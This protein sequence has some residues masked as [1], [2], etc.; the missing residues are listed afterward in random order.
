M[1][2]LLL[3]ELN[4]YFSS[5]IAY[6]VICVFLVANAVSLWLLPD[7]NLLDSGYADLRPFF[8]YAPYIFLFLIPA[9]TMRSLAEEKNLGTLESLITKPISETKIILAKYLAALILVL[10]AVLPTLIY[11]GSL[12]KLGDPVGNIDS[13][14]VMGSYIGLL[15]LASVYI[16]IGIFASSIT[17]SQIVALL[18]SVLICLV[19]TL[20]FQML[21]S[22]RTFRSLDLFLQEMGVLT[23]YVSMSRGVIDTRDVVYFLSANAVFLLG[24]KTVLQKRKW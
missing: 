12:Y 10:I 9:V 2:A 23:H 18:L 19:V 24:T 17:D 3:K 21:G 8:Q 13:G 1:L 14:S 22:L 7:M 20:G 4:S 11:Y 6:V 15:M 5:L 16:A